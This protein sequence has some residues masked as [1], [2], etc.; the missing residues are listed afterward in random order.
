MFKIP[1]EIGIPLG[2]IER[3]E[4]MQFGEGGPGHSEHLRGPVELHRAGPEW[5]HTTIK[6]QITICKLAHIAHHFSLGMVF[7]KCLMRQ[8]RTASLKFGWQREATFLRRYQ[9]GFSKQCANK[10]S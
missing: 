4:W 5:N 10:C 2:L 9:C 7:L 6:G 1:H 8:K 3:R